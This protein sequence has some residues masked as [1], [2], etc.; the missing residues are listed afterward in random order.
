VQASTA[1]VCGAAPMV[2]ASQEELRRLGVSDKDI[3]TDAFVP[4]GK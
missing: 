3:H 4:S 2:K 1:I